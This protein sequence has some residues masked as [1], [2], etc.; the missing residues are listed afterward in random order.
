MTL[1]TFPGD[2]PS[3]ER[4]TPRRNNYYVQMSYELQSSGPLSGGVHALHGGSPGDAGCNGC[5]DCCYLPEKS[6]TSE[7][8]GRLHLLYAELEE[9]NGQLRITP[10]PARSGWHIMHDACVFRR[11]DTPVS[12]GGC[13]I[14]EDR[15]GTCAVFS[16]AL[17]LQMRRD[18][19]ADSRDSGP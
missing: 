8:A 16:C 7:E 17:L 3:V 15:P 18:S 19:Y 14:Y 11:E 4:L 1:F 12:Q 10:D 9:P 5:V 2:I 6:I 13:R